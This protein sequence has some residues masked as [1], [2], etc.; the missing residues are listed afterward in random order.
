MSGER[1]EHMT[2]L[3]CLR[4]EMRR[5]G[6]TPN[7][8]TSKAVGMVLDIISESKDT[9][10]NIAEAE[11]YRT[12]IRN[13]IDG[14]VLELRSMRRSIEREKREWESERDRIEKEI[15][16]IKEESVEYIE[17]FQKSLMETETPE[18]RDAM[19]IAQLFINSVDV[20]TKY[21]NTA[22]IIGLSAILSGSGINSMQELKKINPK[23]FNEE[24]IDRMKGVII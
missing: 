14:S 16:A 5:R 23:L 9:Y 15:K 12:N 22:F 7:Q 18:G 11:Q 10:I 17:N 24:K 20:D 4:A 21:D 2:G 6:A 19:R 3:E 13:Q 1:K 8:I